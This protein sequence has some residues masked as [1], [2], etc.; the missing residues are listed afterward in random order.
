MMSNEEIKQLMEFLKSKVPLQ[1]DMNV[2]NLKYD[3]NSPY[4]KIYK[5][6]LELK[7]KINKLEGR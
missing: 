7:E 4:Y 5:Y 2:Q 3:D 1:F 6:I